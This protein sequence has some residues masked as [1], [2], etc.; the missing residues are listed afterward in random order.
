MKIIW[1]T[2]SFLDYRV[3]VYQ[4]LD[5][6]VKG[7]LF[8]IYSKEFTPQRSW[9]KLET[10]LDGRAIGLEG[11]RTIGY[12]GNITTEM[13]NKGLRIPY[14]PGL[15]GTLKSLQ[16][17][18]LIGDG[19][20]QWTVAAFIHRLW[21]G[22]PLVVCYERTAHTERNAQWY[23]TL[24]RK[25][26]V[27]FIDAICCN[28]RLSGEYTES[29]GMPQERITIGHMAA[30]T[31]SLA[32]QTAAVTAD[33]INAI[34]DRAGLN[35]MRAVFL[36]VSQLIKR[37]GIDHLLRGWKSFTTNSPAASAL[38]IIGEGP[39]KE[40]LELL[41][42]R[43]RISG[44]HFIGTVDYDEIHKYY[45]LA[46][47]FVIPTLEDNWSLVVPEAMA[48]GLPIL[49]SKYN[50]CWP[51][52]VHENLN[53]WVFDPM[54]LQDTVQCLNKALANAERLKELGEASKRIVAGHTPLHAA[55]SIYQAC[56]I[57]MQR[58][59]SKS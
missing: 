13:A 58:R 2:R 7:E 9:K 44:V 54:D 56:E 38:V 12:R 39:E 47:A 53:G 5:D 15:Y 28:G 37:K 29:L 49:C 52:L 31:E 26:M 48:C 1:A 19:F 4:A 24:F 59:N 55:Q 32:R 40:N 20:F 14:Q 3:P 21:H 18:L 57:A 45:A 16:P 46:D 27:P 6:L 51:E 17:D 36:S 11:E 25:L 10:V 35:D 33:E 50:G 43:E 23:R 42:K 34:K 41:C 8:V 22:T 30:D